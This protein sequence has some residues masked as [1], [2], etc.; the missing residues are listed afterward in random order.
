M[1]IRLR[2]IMSTQNKK[3]LYINAQLLGKIDT[4]LD[5]SGTDKEDILKIKNL[6]VRK[7]L[8]EVHLHSF[9]EVKEVKIVHG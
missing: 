3:F 2:K 1:P 8:P 6:T 7:G 9:K 5:C 4:I